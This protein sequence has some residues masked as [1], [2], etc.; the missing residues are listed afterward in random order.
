MKNYII[1][2]LIVIAIPVFVALAQTFTGEAFH[3]T[4]YTVIII[5]ILRK[6]VL[7]LIDNNEH[8]INIFGVTERKTKSQI[9]KDFA[10]KH[11]V[12]IV[13]S[14]TVKIEPSDLLGM[15]KVKRF[16]LFVYDKTSGTAEYKGSF[17]TKEAAME[18]YVKS[19][20]GMFDL[21]DSLLKEFVNR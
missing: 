1:T 16:D 7:S 8:N 15:L 14:N 4:M 18:V 11:G 10:K 17:P 2:F 20:Y 3:S 9:V 6:E 13:Q 5:L 19:G 12:P 21:Y